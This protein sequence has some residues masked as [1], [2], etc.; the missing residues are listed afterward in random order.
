[1]IFLAREGLSYAILKEMPEADQV[2]LR[3]EPWRF[4]LHGKKRSNA[5]DSNEN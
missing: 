3:R 2:D 4:R 5:S 1:M